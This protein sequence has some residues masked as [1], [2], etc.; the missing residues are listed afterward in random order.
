MTPFAV[1]VF[2]RSQEYDDDYAQVDNLPFP[3]KIYGQSST[4][5]FLESNGVRERYC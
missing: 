2:D 3:V 4:T 1:S 5:I